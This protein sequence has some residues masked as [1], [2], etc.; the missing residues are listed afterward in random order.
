MGQ[1]CVTPY[2]SSSSTNAPL[3]L[4]FTPIHGMGSP[5][6]QTARNHEGVPASVFSG[7]QVQS[8]AWLLVLAVAPEALLP[9]TNAQLLCSL[10]WLLLC[11]RLVPSERAPIRPQSPGPHLVGPVTPMLDQ[12]RGSSCTIHP[13]TQNRE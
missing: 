5:L 4:K 10:R 11:A 7:L 6:P 12:G 8:F 13:H 9:Q 2:L 1:K 3:A